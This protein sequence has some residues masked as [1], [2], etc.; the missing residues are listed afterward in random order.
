MDICDRQ[1]VCPTLVGLPP[2]DHAA[3]ED[4]LRAVAAVAVAAAAVRARRRGVGGF[5]AAALCGADSIVRPEFHPKVHT[6]I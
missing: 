2:P 3:D 6:I 5:P 1:V 4:C